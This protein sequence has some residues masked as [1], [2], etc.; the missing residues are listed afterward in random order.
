MLQAKAIAT[1]AKG[2]SR[3]VSGTIHE[4]PWRS[5]SML[6]LLAIF[7]TTASWVPVGS[8]SISSPSASSYWGLSP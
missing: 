5:H 3:Q 7:P 8:M 2:R 4:Y 6:S 1:S